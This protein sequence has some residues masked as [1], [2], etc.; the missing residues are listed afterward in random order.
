M[1]TAS[2]LR[3]AF[4]GGLA[5]SLSRPVALRTDLAVGVPLSEGSPVGTSVLVMR[6]CDY[7][8][9]AMC[10]K[11]FAG[12]SSPAAIARLEIPLDA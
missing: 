8:R 3:F 1:G 9:P 12:P 2:V 5:V 11:C 7:R 4:V 6:G 10:G